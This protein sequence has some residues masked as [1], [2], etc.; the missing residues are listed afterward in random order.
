[1]ENKE[2][3]S[4]YDKIA[5]EYDNSRFENSYGR[6]IDSQERRFLEKSA[7]HDCQGP[8]LEL[9]CGTGRLTGYA[10]HALDASAQ[11][12]AFAQKKHPSV[13]FTLASAT[14]TGYAPESF[15]VVFSFHLLMHLSL[16]E[17]GAVIDEAWRI[18]APGGRLIFDI[19]SLKRRELLRQRKEGWHAALALSSEQVLQM[20][21]GRFSM[22]RSHGVMMLP[23]HRLPSFARAALTGID[24][25]LCGS[26]MKEYSSY[27]IFELKK[28]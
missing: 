16:E 12:M 7:L 11:M 17:V 9:A 2:V 15:D 4:Y 18:L 24:Y 23:V 6:F 27:I 25:A 1:M 10:T 21:R 8:V 14:A 3:V 13:D 26:F 22:E 28:I 20:T 19:P 5:G